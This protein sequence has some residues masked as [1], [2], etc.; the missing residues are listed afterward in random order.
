MVVASDISQELDDT[1]GLQSGLNVLIRANAIK[2]DALKAFHCRLAD[3]VIRPQVQ[4]VHWADFVEGIRLIESGEAAA[5][6]KLA[7]LR[8]LLDRA[9]WRTRLGFSR[10]K[11][12]AKA[13]F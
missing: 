10:G 4:H 3:L 1:T 13:F 6:A 5:E 9:R 11:R 8:A 12:L 2:A 7:D